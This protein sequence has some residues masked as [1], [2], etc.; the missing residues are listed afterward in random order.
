MTNDDFLASSRPTWKEVWKL[1]DEVE[2]LTKERDALR[3]EQR[4]NWTR[5]CERAY[6]KACGIKLEE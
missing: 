6:A 1:R 5:T 3:A 2:Q 4:R